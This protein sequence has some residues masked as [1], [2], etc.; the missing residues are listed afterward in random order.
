MAVVKE[1]LNSDVLSSGMLAA[2]QIENTSMPCQIIPAY[3]K[4]GGIVSLLLDCP[5]QMY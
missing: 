1:V 2:V 5:P 3:S 4:P